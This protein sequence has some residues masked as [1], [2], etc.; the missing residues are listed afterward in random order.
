MAKSQNNVC[1]PLLRGVGLGNGEFMFMGEHTEALNQ[2]RGKNMK[3]VRLPVQIF[4]CTF[5]PEDCQIVSTKLLKGLPAHLS[6]FGH[7]RS[8][9]TVTNP[10]NRRGCHPAL[11]RDALD[12]MGNCSSNDYQP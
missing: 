2:N 5:S 8:M 7:T 10:R 11:S 6:Q 3:R 9:H 1:F 12:R 4:L